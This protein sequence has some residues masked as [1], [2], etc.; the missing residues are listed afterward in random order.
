MLHSR[1]GLKLSVT[2]VI[3]G[4][5]FREYATFMEKTRNIKHGP[6]FFTGSKGRNYDNVSQ[7]L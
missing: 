4:C 5:K 1:S 3:L 2:S 7:F 6:K